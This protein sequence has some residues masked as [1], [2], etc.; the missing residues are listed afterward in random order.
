MEHS[1]PVPEL[2][3]ETA[4]RAALDTMKQR[5]TG[6]LVFA[7]LVF[8]VASV[9]EDGHT[10]VEYVRATAEAAMVGAVADWFAVTALFR[11]PLGVPIPHTA[12]IPNRKDRIGRSLGNFVQNNFLAPGVLTTKLRSVGVAARLAEWLRQPEHA[13]TVAGHAAASVAGGFRVL[14]DED[15]QEWMQ[16]ALVSR[17]RKTQVT[18]LL[19]RVLGLMTQGD[20]HQEL[21]DAVLRLLARL[22]IE[23]RDTIRDKIGDETPWWVPNAVDNKIYEK[24]I[25]SVET[26]LSE[27]YTDPDHPLRARFSEAVTE[28]VERLQHSPEMIERGEALKDEL[29]EHPMLRDY[30][31]SLWSDIKDSTQRHSAESD[32]EFRRRVQDAVAAFGASLAEDADL[33]GKIDGWV[34]QAVLYV[35][36]QY[37]HEVGDLIHST[38]EAWDATDTSRKIELQIGRDLQFIRINGTLVGGLVGLLIH[39]IGQLL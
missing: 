25:A 36:E 7:A 3:D 9:F 4:K 26:T 29:L 30:T 22:L 19:G 18:P 23:N 17:A 28:F 35:V 32:S 37:R 16:H 15:V 8:V 21:L 31:A 39:A 34:E 2:A 27:V 6:L 12:I 5:A 14:R 11:H 20:R 33:R 1:I 10:W 38:V 13:R 24:V